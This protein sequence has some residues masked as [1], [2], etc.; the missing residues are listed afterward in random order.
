MRKN[1][2]VYDSWDLTLPK[3][4]PRSRL[5][6]LDVIGV[7]TPF[8][9]SCTGYIARLAAEHWTSVG[10]LFGHRIAPAANKPSFLSTKFKFEI[11]AWTAFLPGAHSLNGLGAIA[12]DWIE[13]LQTLT[14]RR[15]LRCLTMLRWSNV[16][17]ELSLSRSI[18]AW[19]PLCFQAERNSDGV[20]Y[21]QLLWSL[22]TVEVCPR[23]KRRLETS[24]PHCQKQTRQLDSRSR[25][26]FCCCCRKWLGFSEVSNRNNRAPLGSDEIAYELW[27]AKQMGELIASAPG[28]EADP[29]ISKVTAFVPA[30]IEK[31]TNGNIGA[32]AR[33]VDVKEGTVSAWTRNA[34]GVPRLDLLLRVC[35]RLGAS[36]SDLLTK[37]SVS[38][39]YELINQSLSRMPVVRT[40]RSHENGE[41]RRAFLTALKC[42]PAPSVHEFS[43]SLGYKNSDF[44]RLK[45]S[46]L[47]KKL[48]A[49]Y[50]KSDRYLARKQAPRRILADN[51]IKD[52]LQKALKEPVTP[53]LLEIRKRLGYRSKYQGKEVLQRRFPELCQAV[54]VRR[55]AQQVKYQKR[56][57]RKL[58]TILGEEP[59]P[60]LTEVAKRLGFKGRNYLLEHHPD[61]S[62]A[63]VER[64]SD[65][66]KAQFNGIPDELRAILCEDPPVS[67]LIAATRVGHCDAYLRLRFRDVCQAIARR[68]LLFKKKRRLEKKK[69][70]VK[71]LRAT[72][73]TLDSTG[74]YPSLKQIKAVL[75]VPVG[76]PYDE[77]CAV[78]RDLRSQFKSKRPV[79]GY[80]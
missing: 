28:M 18:H 12:K 3:V 29:P 66:R 13:V 74:V 40:Q 11:Q 55:A 20:V 51:T 32:F 19:C 38:L 27:V 17:S 45:Y 30:C 53:S 14:Q 36:L 69:E 15:D 10:S 59:P 50:R 63:I 75:R 41:I 25:P 31:L 21:D 61:L 39:N 72:A 7:G 46:D 26:G 33:L 58:K 71:R 73:L 6:P 24:C 44:L 52:A 9:E 70:A 68:Y 34:R 16:L 60:T 79:N 8:S 35:Y 48:T 1:F 56:L 23:H 4:R 62:R 67:L 77:A 5:Y 43:A 64:H 47:C 22:V 54:R 80:G 57:S 65:Y 49:R 37:D 78:L 76:L 42:D 2:V